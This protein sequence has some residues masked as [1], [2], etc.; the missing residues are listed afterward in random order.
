LSLKK[1]GI[2][3]GKFCGPRARGKLQKDGGSKRVSLAFLFHPF[4]ERVLRD[5]ARVLSMLHHHLGAPGDLLQR[6]GSVSGLVKVAFDRVLIST[7]FLFSGPG[8][9]KPNPICLQIRI[10]SI[11]FL[12]NQ[13]QGLADGRRARKK[14]K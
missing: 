6:K 9:G 8:H 2:A 7:A 14:R 10:K 1:V 5:L 13:T 11:N 4:F 12:L 3:A